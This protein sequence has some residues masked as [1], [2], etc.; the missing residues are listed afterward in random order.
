MTEHLLSR[1]RMLTLTL[2]GALT[3]PAV[4]AR[5]DEASNDAA[6]IIDKSTATIRSLLRDPE[7]SELPRYIEA[8]RAVVIFPQLI[9]GGFILGGEGG[10]GVLLV[11]GADRSWSAPAF[12]AL[13]AGSIGLQIGGQVSEV[14]LTVMNDGALDSILNRKVK[15]GADVSV[16]VGPIGKGLEASTTANLKDDVYAFSRAVGLFGGGSLEGA[17]L[18]ERNTLNSAYYGAGATARSIVIERRYFNSEADPL[19]TALP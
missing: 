16:A 1:R 15:F 18:F 8:A 5:A 6:S 9:K 10:Y 13:A 19:R 14:V 3:L 2:A 4:G 17:G 7:F 12:F 11:R